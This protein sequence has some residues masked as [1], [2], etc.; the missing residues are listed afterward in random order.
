MKQVTFLLSSA[1]ITLAMMGCGRGGDVVPEEADETQQEAAGIAITAVDPLHNGEIVLGKP[2][3]VDYE[4][5]GTFES[6]QMEIRNR[7]GTLIYSAS[8]ACDPGKHTATWDT[9]WNRGDHVGAYANPARGPYQIK[10]IGRKGEAEGGTSCES[11]PR[12]IGALLAAH[13]TLEDPKPLE[14]EISSGLYPPSVGIG[15][16]P[17]ERIRM[18]LISPTGERIWPG[19]KCPATF[20]EIVMEDLDNDPTSGDEQ[21]REVVSARVSQ[22]MRETTAPLADGTY[23]IIV[24]RV[25]DL[26]GNMGMEGCPDGVLSDEDVSLY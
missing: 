11:Q 3:N 18:G 21:G 10:V 17:G 4:V 19:E 13:V 9:K 7:S 5:T 24:D 8:V 1:A 12:L 25:R 2:V 16:D 22:E 26:A 14:D 15:G 23:R 20:S 6:A